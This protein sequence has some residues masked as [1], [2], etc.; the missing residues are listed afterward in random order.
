MKA[1]EFNSKFI[2]L[3]NKA[4]AIKKYSYGRRGLKFDFLKPNLFLSKDEK[5]MVKAIE[6]QM[7]ELITEFTAQKS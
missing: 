1:Q 3:A 7:S 4:G 6:Q 5:Q 2:N